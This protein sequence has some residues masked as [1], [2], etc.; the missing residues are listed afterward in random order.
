MRGE[1]EEE[2]EDSRDKEPRTVEGERLKAGVIERS[3]VLETGRLAQK[4]KGTLLTP[5]TRDAVTKVHVVAWL[6]RHAIGGCSCPS[7]VDHTVAVTGTH[8]A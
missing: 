5:H 3:G 2:S 7:N 4:L 8:A 6:A 1:E